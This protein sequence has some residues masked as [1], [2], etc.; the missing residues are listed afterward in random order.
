MKKIIFIPLILVLSILSISAV[1]NFK[2]SNQNSLASGSNRDVVLQFITYNGYGNNLYLDNVLTG[3]QPENDVMVSSIVNITYDTTYAFFTNGYDTIHPQVAVSNIGRNP[4]ADIKVFLEINSGQYFDTVTIKT[5]F[6]GQTSFVTFK[7]LDNVINKP[8]FFK[9]YTSFDLDSNRTNDTL[10][11]Y[12]VILPGF[13]RNVLFEE[14]TSNASFACANNNEALDEFINE[15]PLSVNAIKYHLPL[16]STGIDSFYLQNPEQN[17]ERTFY[18]YGQVIAVPNTIVDGKLIAQI[19]YG[20]SLN[21]YNPYNQRLA[22]GTPLSIEVTDERIGND[23]IKTDVTIEVASRLPDRNYRLKIN[24]VQ[25][26]AKS[27]A[28]NGDSI[29]FDIFRRVYPDTIGIIVPEAVGTYNFS[30]TYY[31]EP[32]W[33]DTLIYTSVFVQNYRSKEILN[34]AKSRF[35]VIDPVPEPL[36]INKNYSSKPDIFYSY[37]GNRE[38]LFSSDSIQTSENIELFEGYFPPLN[39]K[40]FNDDGYIT[41]RQYSGINGPTLGGT[42]SVIMDFFNYNIP[43][44]KDTMFSKV[45][46]NLLIADTLRF[47]YAYAQYNTISN[48]DSLIVRISGDGGLTFP[49]EIF[50]KGGIPLSTAPQTTSFFIPSNNTQWKS[51]KFSLSSVVSVD[52]NYANVPDRFILNQNY[53]NPFNPATKINYELPLSNFVTIKVY[54]VLGREIATLVNEK[55]EAGKHEVTFDA[56]SV[57]GGLPSGVYFYSFN[58]EG[59]S[60]TKRMMLLK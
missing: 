19:P 57:N 42:K 55:Q 18:Y 17:N 48:I 29:F 52:N 20:D 39:W 56:G 13:R 58:S 45:Y 44:Q 26:Y 1:I 49:L 7:T 22:K 30:Y 50:R 6:T 10:R 23:S 47:D 54:N 3:I 21:L 37:K 16:G 11:Q 14:F 59:Y 28:A 12:S 15:N 27:F 25:R 2:H 34:C 36:A 53:P 41:F 38:V 43:G 8:L 4:A 46:A 31:V 60:E 33:D 5:L 35:I 32:E 40:V 51:F 9:S 24:A